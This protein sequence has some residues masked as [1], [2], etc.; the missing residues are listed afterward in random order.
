MDTVNTI[1]YRWGIMLNGCAAE[2]ECSEAHI[3]TSAGRFYPLADFKKCLQCGRQMVMA[4]LI[5]DP[6]RDICRECPVKV[7]GEQSL[8]QKLLRWVHDIIHS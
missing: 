5:E 3:V 8:W 2:C 1:A 6:E 4:E 7:A